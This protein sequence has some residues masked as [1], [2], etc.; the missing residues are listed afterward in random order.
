MADTELDTFLGAGSEPASAPEPQQA[1]PPEPPEQD[2]P[3]QDEGVAEPDDADEAV[4]EPR[5][6]ERTVPLSALQKAR[7]DWKAKAVRAETERDELRRQLEEAKRVASAPPQQ[8]PQ[9]QQPI[10]PAE[11]PAGY[12]ALIQQ[13]VLNERLNTSELL[14]RRE[15]GAE[16]VD[17]AIAEFKQAAAK[18]PSLF[19]KLYQQPDP[20]SWLVKQVEV[21]KL[22]REIGDDPKAYRE[23]L[24]AEIEAELAGR[25]TE[26]GAPVSPAARLPPSLANARSAAPRS[27]GAWSG[28]TPLQDLFPNR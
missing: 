5:P 16:A 7:E 11:D 9:Y 25:M 26:Q 12:H 23:R 17:A 13:T 4:P 2:E 28:P 1:P 24:R 6:G 3:E 22:Q 21:M 18:D 15:I 19:P 27:N 10:N 14:V 20:Y 8:Q